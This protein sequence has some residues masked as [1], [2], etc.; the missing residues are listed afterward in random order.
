M[1]NKINVVFVISLTFVICYLVLKICNKPNPEFFSTNN[2][3]NNGDNDNNNNNDKAKLPL[4]IAIET[5]RKNFDNQEKA[6]NRQNQ[7]IDILKR[8]VDSLRQDLVI[9]KKQEQDENLSIQN[10]INLGDSVAQAL[11]VEGG[12]TLGRMVNGKMKNT[13]G[14]KENKSMDSNGRNYNLHF[15]LKD[16]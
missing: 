14:L 1:K 2:D 11:R 16:E 13:P 4:E 9:M 15:N 10:S 6:Q 5:K 3:N 7:E 12:Q 8:K